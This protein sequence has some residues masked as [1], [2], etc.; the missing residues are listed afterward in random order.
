ME[1]LS[2]FMEL[3]NYIDNVSL[4]LLRFL[5]VIG[6]IVFGIIKCI[7]SVRKNYF[8]GKKRCVIVSMLSIAIGVASWFFNM[9]WFR[10]CLTLLLVPVIHS[11]IFF[12][13]NLS[14]AKYFEKSPEI[15][16]L[17]ICFIVTFLIFYII[18]PDFPIG[19]DGTMFFFFGLI[20]NVVFTGFAILI[21]AAA[22]IGHIV[23][24]L[25]QI[26][27]INKTKKNL[28]RK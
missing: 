18:A 6:L 10:F 16:K 24:L 7:Q 11:V 23:V 22:L 8:S 1:R 26:A 12:Y 21:S 28:I 3:W 14:A 4:W 9:G 27:K 2:V 19:N 13:M 17:N 5:A 15:K 20:N 25:M